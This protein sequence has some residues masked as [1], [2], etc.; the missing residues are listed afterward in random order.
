MTILFQ[1]EEAGAS[2]P[3]FSGRKKILVP[4]MGQFGRRGIVKSTKN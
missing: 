2:V 1:L 3:N 4:D